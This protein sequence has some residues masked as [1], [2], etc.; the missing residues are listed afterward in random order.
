V[1][2][3]RSK[4]YMRGTVSS[5]AF[6]ILSDPVSG[7]GGCEPTASPGRCCCAVIGQGVSCD[8]ALY[9]PIYCAHPGGSAIAASLGADQ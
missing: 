7:P 4:K 3:V 8:V 1:D 5:S 6:E 2:G 9:P